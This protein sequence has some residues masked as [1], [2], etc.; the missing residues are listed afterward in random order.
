MFDAS[1]PEWPEFAAKVNMRITELQAALESPVDL[2]ETNRLR[3]AIGE[4]RRLVS[5]AVPITTPETPRYS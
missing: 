1:H 4:L 3:G 5:D 2:H